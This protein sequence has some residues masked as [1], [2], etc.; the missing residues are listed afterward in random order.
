MKKLLLAGAVALLPTLAHATSLLQFAEVGTDEF[1]A[2]NPAALPLLSKTHLAVDAAITISSLLGNPGITSGFLT[3][4]ADNSGAATTVGGNI[5]QN[6]SGTF[7]ITSAAACGGTNYLSGVFTDEALGQ[8]GGSG[9]TVNVVNP[10]DTLTLTSSVIAA[11]LLGAPSAFD[12]D[13]SNVSPALA[14]T[15]GDS[16][17]AFTASFAGSAS[18]TPVPEP[19]SLVLLGVGLLGVG[20]VA[21]R[22]RS[23]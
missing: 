16:V 1:A 3:V 9:V 5:S 2:T 15:A 19:A 12:M 8:A 21:R 13:L 10:P 6:F 4:S 20:F 17:R 22:K 18:A 11:S 14:E 7:C 23:V